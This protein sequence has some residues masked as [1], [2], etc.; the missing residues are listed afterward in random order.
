[1]S[2]SRMLALLPKIDRGG[3]VEV[4]VHFDGEAPR[5]ANSVSFLAGKR[6]AGGVHPV[7]NP[8]FDPAD[9]SLLVTRSGSRGEHV[10]VSLYRIAADDTVEEFSG[11]ISNPTAIA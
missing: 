4:A 9:G 1:A 11:D 2:K 8:A 10:P 7:A 3:E 5:A 6:L